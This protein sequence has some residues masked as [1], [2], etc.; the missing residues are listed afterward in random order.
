MSV[1]AMLVVVVAAATAAAAPPTPPTLPAQSTML[2]HHVCL[3]NVS[4]VCP[5]GPS[6]SLMVVYYDYPS[7]RNRQ[8]MIS[9]SGRANLSTLFQ[10]WQ[11][12]VHVHAGA[13]G[14]PPGSL[15][16][17]VYMLG[18]NEAQGLMCFLD[19]VPNAT[20]PSP[21]LAG[22]V[23][24]GTASFGANA[25]SPWGAAVETHVWEQDMWMAGNT[26]QTMVSV[27]TGAV[28]GYRRL[29]QDVEQF[30]IGA[31]TPSVPAGALDE[32]SGMK[33]QGQQGQGGT[34][35]VVVAGRVDASTMR[36]MGM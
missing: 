34:D 19:T 14:G 2:L 6:Q 16:W 32:P 26:V 35:E 20:F 10:V 29:A 9:V 11:R 27:D 28:V 22:A 18:A 25:H 36:R 8:D 5:S 13:A 7:R 17:D 1:G 4:H 23:Y 3:G 24:K 33:C 21:S 30:V 31:I 12:P 15:H